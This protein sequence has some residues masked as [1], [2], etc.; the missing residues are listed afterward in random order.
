MLPAPH[1]SI[2]ALLVLSMFSTVLGQDVDCGQTCGAGGC[3]TSNAAKGCCG[4][5]GNGGECQ[6]S[7]AAKPSAEKSCCSKPA[8]AALPSCCTAKHTKAAKYHDCTTSKTALTTC[9]TG[10]PCVQNNEFPPVPLEQQS[11][12]AD[13]LKLPVLDHAP[14]L[15][16]L[17]A[18]HELSS[19]YSLPDHSPPPRAGQTLRLWIC[20]W[21][22]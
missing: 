21:T 3:Q 13:L 20:S 15:A 9:S 10:C 14:V 5:C 7:K 19:G 17:P 11:R 8:K 16:V 18:A 1:N 22:T 6:C 4:S 2:A 12:V